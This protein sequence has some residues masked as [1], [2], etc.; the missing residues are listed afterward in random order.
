MRKSQEFVT[1]I[2]YP[3]IPRLKIQKMRPNYSFLSNSELI[4]NPISHE[5]MVHL[6]YMSHGYMV[7]LTRALEATIAFARICA[8]WKMYKKLLP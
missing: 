3:P 6:I 1:P 2:T 8:N 5:Y 4:P 7:H